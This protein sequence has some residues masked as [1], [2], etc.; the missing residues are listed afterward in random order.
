MIRTYLAI[1]LSAFLLFFPGGG[2]GVV[3]AQEKTC[4]KPVEHM[5]ATEFD[6][7][8]EAKR[9]LHILNAKDADRFSRVM[10]TVIGHEGAGVN[11]FDGFLDEI[12]VYKF[13][14]TSAFLLG[15]KDGCYKAYRVHRLDTVNSALEK[16]LKGDL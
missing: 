8:N 5:N 2:T 9:V 1:A 6:K 11:K 4:P 12:K 10:Q 14:P 3:N 15:F 16:Y 7:R 13:Y